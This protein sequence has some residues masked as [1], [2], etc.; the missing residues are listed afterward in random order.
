MQIK[1]LLLAAAA[2]GTVAAPAQKIKKTEG[3]IAPFKAEKSVNIEFSY[4]NMSVGKFKTEKEYVDT[5]TTEYN[6]SEA[7]KGDKWAKAWVDDRAARYENKF[8]GLF[9]EASGK[10]ED[11]S[12][13]YT[14]IFRTSFTEP[15]FNVGVMRKNAYIDGEVLIVETANKKNIIARLLVEKAPGRDVMGYDFDTGW[16]IS[17]AYAKAGK[18]LG[19]LLK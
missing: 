5:K 6:K 19:K 7:G 10:K 1:L 14:L 15:G 8:T 2:F 18:S 4:E 16:R 11:A 12:A 3:D 9:T 13:K 17:E